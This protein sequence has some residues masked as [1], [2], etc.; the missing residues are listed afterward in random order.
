MN[1]LDKIDAYFEN[2]P[3]EV[4]LQGW[5]KYEKL[6]QVGPTVFKF[7]ENILSQDQTSKD[8]GKNQ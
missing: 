1:M 4:V 5:S 7:I 2:T 3:K 8:D 6:D